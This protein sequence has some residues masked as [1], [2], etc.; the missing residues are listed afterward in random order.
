MSSKN[1]KFIKYLFIRI[2]DV[3]QIFLFPGMTDGQ[4]DDV[5]KW[6]KNQ[7]CDVLK[8]RQMRGGVGKKSPKTEMDNPLFL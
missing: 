1:F 6:L 8:M 5:T 2:R 4:T 3:H 7:P